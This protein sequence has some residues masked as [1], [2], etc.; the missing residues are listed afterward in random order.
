[1]PCFSKGLY[2]LNLC[3]QEVSRAGSPLISR[4]VST[5]GVLMMANV[6]AAQSISGDG[7][8]GTTVATP[9]TPRDFVITNGTATG[10]HLFHSFREFSIPTG[11]S[12]TF[13]LVNTPG[14]NM[15][16]GRVTGGTASNI[17]GVI[18]TLNGGPVNVFLLNP[19]G[20]VFGPGAQLNI[21]GSFLATTASTIQFANGGSFG[22]TASTAPLLTMSVP[23]GLQMGTNPGAISVQGT[24]HT[25]TSQDES[26]FTPIIQLTRPGLQ[27]RPGQTLALVGGDIRFHNGVAAAAQGRVEVGSVAAGS[28][29]LEPVAAGWRLGYGNATR[30]GD[31]TLTGR[32]LLDSSGAAAGTIQLQG[33]QIR[34]QDGAIILAQSQGAQPGGPVQITATELFQASGVSDRLIRSGILSESLGFGKTSRIAI[35]APTIQVQQGAQIATKN[36]NRAHGGDI[37]LTAPQL[38]QIDGISL[39]NPI[40]SSTIGTGTL[41]QFAS[42]TITIRA[43]NLQLLNGSNV[44]TTT[45]SQGDSGSIGVEADTITILGIS[46]VGAST[47]LGATSFGDGD[48]GNVTVQARTLRLVDGGVIS[49][50][51]YAKG[52]AGSIVVNASESVDVTGFSLAPG[53]P[54]RSS[55]TSSVLIPSPQFRA[56]LRLF[57]APSGAAGSVTVNSPRVSFS[58][59]ATTSVRNLG[60]GQGGTLTITAREIHLSQ[61]SNLSAATVSGLGGDIILTADLLTLRQGSSL[62]ATAGGIGAGGDIRITAPMLLGTENSDIF[63]N[64]VAGRGGTIQISTQGIFGLKFRPQLTADSDITASSE[65]GVSGTVQI[66]TP[67]IDPNAG[68]VNIAVDLI[69]PNQQVAS[70]C[71]DV[72]ES[73][74]VV[75][76]RGGMPLDPTQGD[77]LD[78]PWQDLRTP[79]PLAQNSTARVHAPT[80][81]RQNPTV[82]P[83]GLREA[84]RW[85]RTA[86]GT[87]ILTA[88]AAT[89]V[90]PMA[91]CNLTADRH[92]RSDNF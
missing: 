62:T 63:A 42:G 21:G 70:G 61:R 49:G 85:Y 57:A 20:I 23:M 29:S 56:A 40:Q 25:L 67:G 27:L 15:L 69:D 24:G 30:F 22:V 68:L 19:S 58:N 51:A 81:S 36:F 89:A 31:V 10:Q 4:L 7:T 72:Q 26:G 75:T 48:A 11:G 45:F 13:D 17:N 64:A 77:R 3:I 2:S 55:I 86:N 34:L 37:V 46:P 59:N 83:T 16:F 92:N 6:A 5:L 91:T 88:E 9:N 32:S 78:R 60:T 53:E 80:D 41:G 76:G 65:L 52:D 12:A 47:A 82:P 54:L 74:F 71:A 38:L 44:V 33:R 18:Q 43:G 1:M 84:T 14:V 79:A 8:L 28:V 35:A 66:N 90:I 39:L 50:T 73:S 87:V